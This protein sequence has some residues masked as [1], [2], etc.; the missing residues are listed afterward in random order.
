MLAVG[1]LFAC[2]DKL[3]LSLASHVLMCGD[4]GNDVG[5]LK[6]ADDGVHVA[7]FPLWITVV[8]SWLVSNESS[9]TW[10]VPKTCMPHDS[11]TKIGQDLLFGDAP[12]GVDVLCYPQADAGLALLAG[13][14]NASISVPQPCSERLVWLLVHVL[15]QKTARCCVCW[16]SPCRWTL[17]TT[18]KS[19]RQQRIPKSRQRR[20]R[21]TGDWETASVT[22]SSQWLCFAMLMVDVMKVL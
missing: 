15:G 3:P 18:M 16:F 10:L 20:Y 6:Q 2:S 1:F 9:L 4:G 8:F 5:A 13:Y 7:G 22:K 19:L 17:L 12:L 11:Q 21:K 14:G